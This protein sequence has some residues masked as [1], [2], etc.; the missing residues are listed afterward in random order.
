V[1]GI[2]DQIRGVYKPHHL[3]DQGF[4]KRLPSRPRYIPNDSFAPA[5]IVVRRGAWFSRHA[6]CDL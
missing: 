3:R 6:V 4:T 5:C 2:A 1:W